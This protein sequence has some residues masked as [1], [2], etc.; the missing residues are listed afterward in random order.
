M[1]EELKQRWDR[2]EAE[3]KVNLICFVSEYDN[4]HCYDSLAYKRAPIGFDCL[5]STRFLPLMR[6]LG[7]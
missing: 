3:W 5:L 4:R 6:G 2:G 7:T 1:A